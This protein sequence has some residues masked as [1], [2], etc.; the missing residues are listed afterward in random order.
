MQKV[1]Y[2][3]NLAYG[4][5]GCPSEAGMDWLGRF[6]GLPGP[7]G[8]RSLCQ[9]PSLAQG[10]LPAHPTIKQNEG[11]SKR[12]QNRTHSGPKGEIRAN[13]EGAEAVTAASQASEPQKENFRG[14]WVAGLLFCR[15]RDFRYLSHLDEHSYTCHIR[16]PSAR[17]GKHTQNQ[18]L[19]SQIKMSV[20]KGQ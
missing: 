17:L 13:V 9:V 6:P 8:L 16:C 3:L 1:N 5:G 18:V 14:R 20:T 4:E 2:L 7:G 10:S 12:Q 19:I 11:W 15:I